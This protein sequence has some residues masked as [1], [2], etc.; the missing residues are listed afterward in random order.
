MLA[1]IIVATA[2]ARLIEQRSIYEASLG[3]PMRKWRG[4]A[5]SGTGAKRHD[6]RKLSPRSVNRRQGGRPD[7]PSR[8]SIPL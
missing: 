5:T 4:E 7:C 8:P 6:Y 2:T 3:S 1:A